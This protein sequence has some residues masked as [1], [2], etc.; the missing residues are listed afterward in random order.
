MKEVTDE[1]IYNELKELLT[2]PSNKRGRQ[3]IIQTGPEGKKAFDEILKEA[4]LNELLDH[5]IYRCN[6]LIKN[7]IITPMRKAQ[8]LKLIK[9]HQYDNTTMVFKILDNYEKQ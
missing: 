9:T 6:E 5:V 4:S 7:G 2:R 3:I 8:L 1:D